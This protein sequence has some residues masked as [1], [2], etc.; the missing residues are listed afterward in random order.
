MTMYYFFIKVLYSSFMASNHLGS[1]NASFTKSNASWIRAVV[2]NL[3][4]NTL[5]LLLVVME[6]VFG[7]VLKRI[8]VCEVGWDGDGC[9]WED[10]LICSPEDGV[11]VWNGEWEVFGEGELIYG[12]VNGVCVWNGG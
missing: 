11:C 10:E 1:Y 6:W 3:G 4:L 2:Y 9:S 12:S 8:G 5:A 7:Y